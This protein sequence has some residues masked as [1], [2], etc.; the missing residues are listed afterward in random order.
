MTVNSREGSSKRFY[1]GSS[2]D[3]SY[4]CGGEERG[5]CVSSEVEGEGLV[6]D[7]KGGEGREVGWVWV[8]VGREKG[9]NIRRESSSEEQ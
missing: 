2:F 1:E 9:E 4:C 5:L 7:G 3:G 6:R 8:W